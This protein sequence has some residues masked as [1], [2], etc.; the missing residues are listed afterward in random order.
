M[1]DF[2]LTT[3]CGFAHVFEDVAPCPQDIAKRTF[4][5]KEVGYLRGDHDGRRWWTDFFPVRPELMTPEIK[6]EFQRLA[7]DI[8]ETPP[9][10]AGISG[11]IAFGSKYPEAQQRDGTMMRYNFYYEGESANY[12]IQFLDIPKNQNIYIHIFAK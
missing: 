7:A 1:K 8:L 4:P 2:N 12:R 6:D 9:I 3:A 10:K 5:K 11:I